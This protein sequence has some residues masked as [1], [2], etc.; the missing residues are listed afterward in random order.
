MRRFLS[1]GAGVQSSTL[2]LMACR[3]EFAEVPEAA[4]FADTQWEP[5]EVYTWL[6]ELE[7]IGGGVIPIHRVSAGNIRKMA[8]TK[9]EGGKGYRR[10]SL[11]VF[12]GS[13]QGAEGMLFRQCTSEF[14]LRPIRKEVRRL[15][16]V[17]VGRRVPAAVLAEQWIG[18][19][20]D[21]ALRMK[22]SGEKWLTNRYPLIERQMS[23][24]DCLK[25]LAAAGFAQPA[26]S[27]CLGCPYTNDARWRSMKADRP[28][29]FAD[30]VDFDRTIRHGLTG[31]THPAY[32][33]R[34]LT[35]LDEVDFSTAED[36]GQLN[37]FINEC[38]GMC[39]V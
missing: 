28:T 21:E 13:Q 26:K 38:E 29:E 5:A 30:A 22:D 33:H 16:G 6:D 10:V 11:P 2:Y 3:G 17:K 39:G 35:P 18:I 37:M 31:V 25:W 32:L 9:M 34:S 36:R 19:S 12:L 23:R 15:L 27:A 8:L 24:T 20:L 1:L 14:K 7:R 4:I